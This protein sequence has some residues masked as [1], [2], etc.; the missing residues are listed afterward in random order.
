MPGRTVLQSRLVAQLPTMR[1]PFPLME[2]FSGLL[3]T[4]LLS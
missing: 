3:G 4:D 1:A 2:A